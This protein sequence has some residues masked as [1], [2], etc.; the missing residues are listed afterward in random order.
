MNEMS[1]IR[2]HLANLRRRYDEWGDQHLD[3]W[4]RV[5]F[6]LAKAMRPIWRPLKAVI[7]C[8]EQLWRHGQTV[9]AKTSIDLTQQAREQYRAATVYG[10]PPIKYYLYALYN[11][12]RR[13]GQYIPKRTWGR[14]LEYLLSEKGAGD[15][16]IL[17]DK[18]VTDQH[19]RQKGLPTI[20][21]L[22]E[23]ENGEVISRDWTARSVL[24]GIDLFSKPAVAN[25][26]RGAHR[27]R[28][29]S[30]G[31]YRA[32]DGAVVGQTELV[33][34]LKH[35]SKGKVVLLQPRVANHA[36]LQKLSGDTL[37]S[38]RIITMRRPQERARYLIGSISLPVG[39]VVGSN[40]QFGVLR[41]PIEEATGRLGVSYD[42]KDISRVMEPISVH[43]VTGGRIEGFELPFWKET[44]DLAIQAHETFTDIA[45]IG[46][47]IALTPDGPVIIEGNS[48]P[49]ADMLQVS[50]KKPLGATDFPVLYIA[51]LECATR[52]SRENPS[53]CYDHRFSKST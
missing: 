33:D 30:D 1:H 50:H 22:A 46:W 45:L 51:N 16:E 31:R 12:S 2:A 21:I 9:R 40:T 52:P 11:D 53:R 38:L 4:P 48:N 42:Q 18:R 23:F 14:L 26:G 44:V 8:V 43:P 19:F 20:P 13:M 47:D 35:Q 29:R 41:A 25:Q 27:W 39:D 17:D 24:P 36:Q 37:V 6:R 3:G 7:Q 15:R 32:E 34:R 28:I 49:G 5:K 10:I